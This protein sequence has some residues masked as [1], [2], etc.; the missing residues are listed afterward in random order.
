MTGRWLCPIK[1]DRTLPVGKNMFW[2]L[3]VNDR[4]LRVQ[5]PVI[6]IGASGQHFD[7]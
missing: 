6:S 4:T 5:R 3:T 1:H 7:R 2:T